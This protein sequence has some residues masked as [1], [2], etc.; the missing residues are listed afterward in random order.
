MGV[1][2]LSIPYETSNQLPNTVIDYVKHSLKTIVLDNATVQNDLLTDE[3]LIQQQPSSLLCAPI[4]DRG[5]LIGL[6]YLE[7]KLI[8]GVFTRERLEVINLLST[9]AAISL[10]NAQLYAQQQQKTWEIAQKEEEYR[11]IF[12]ASMMD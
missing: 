4:L 12:E 5:K 8:K 3:Y 6:L 9:Q 2:H 1:T 11:S 7:N 10:Q